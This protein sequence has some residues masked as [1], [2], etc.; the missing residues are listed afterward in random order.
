MRGSG[1]RYTRS[2][3]G[4]TLP[5]LVAVALVTTLFSAS[6]VGTALATESSALKPM[7]AT[8]VPSAAQISSTETSEPAEEQE[9][10]SPSSTPTE[11]QSTESTGSKENS[12]ESAKKAG[13][14]SQSTDRDKD[15]SSSVD[16]EGVMV[17]PGVTL[18]IMP[19]AAVT[20]G[21]GITVTVTPDWVTK[22]GT[23]TI[24][25]TD[26]NDSG[27]SFTQ[28]SVTGIPSSY[29]V[30]NSAVI[31]TS[32]RILSIPKG[33]G[34]PIITTFTVKVPNA[35]NASLSD[36][37]VTRS[38]NS[39]N[40]VTDFDNGTFDYIGNAKPVLPPA[41]VPNYKWDDP[42]KVD[43]SVCSWIYDDSNPWDLIIGAQYGPCDG[44]YTVWPTA[45]IA[46]PQTKNNVVIFN[47]KWA[48]LRSTNGPAAT[49]SGFPTAENYCSDKEYW[50]WYPGASVTNTDNMNK[51]LVVNGKNTGD[52]RVITTTVSG[53]TPG[54]T[55]AIFG[56]T[57]NISW[58]Q[59]NDVKPVQV[60]FAV[61]SGGT[62][63]LIGRSNAL[64]TQGGNV[65]G[66][67]KPNPGWTTFQG[68]FTATA[69]SAT[70]VLRAQN[71]EGYGNDFAFDNL[72]MYP[73]AKAL[74]NVPVKD[75]G[76][77]AIDKAFNSSVP[78]D[79]SNVQFSG[80]YTCV[81]SGETVASG[82]WKR[83]GNGA[84]TLTSSSGNAGTT[85]LIP[86]GA[87]CSATETTPTGV[88]AGRTWG[89]PDFTGP[90]TITS[91]TTQK[92]TVTNNSIKLK[93]SVAW[94]KVAKGTTTLLE[95]SK[96]KLVGPAPATT[97]KQINDCVAASATQC[98]GPDIDPIA[99]QLKL[100]DLDLG[101]YKLY[102]TQAPAGYTRLETPTE[103]TIS[104]SQPD[105]ALSN[106]ENEQRPPLTI[107]LTGGMGA[108]MFLY[109]GTLILGLLAL[110]AAI[111]RWR[112]RRLA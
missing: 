20:G 22:G 2:D 86:V 99:G 53:L 89:T 33:S 3:V 49:G 96:W 15:S 81:L 1:S 109:G 31:S 77:L 78:A 74:F 57:A 66:C 75:V 9:L 105:K 63:N 88:L 7:A 27:A 84:A 62:N 50:T 6:L 38:S 23:F 25:I 97:E 90:V 54:A 18:S 55:Y 39:P 19:Y 101:S 5:R 35:A 12:D 94:S 56:D 34:S 29:V 76:S 65:A 98:P 60:E 28:Y 44:Q 71:G 79:G 68:Q 72:R 36:V 87:S 42:T 58:Q 46:G 104:D 32:P 91:G 30:S 41:N 13:Q 14:D 103:F 112:V 82:T 106:I 59:S 37:M 40:L 111:Q 102:E 8:A 45:A 4:P 107:P 47:N 67:K 10:P 80:A 69:T 26:T 11:S 52:D 48:D 110:T 64:P 51:I 43:T 73:M 92:I 16:T 70:I 83:T 21:D 108:D 24:T 61:Q 85:Q 95:G 17:S 100:K 93:G